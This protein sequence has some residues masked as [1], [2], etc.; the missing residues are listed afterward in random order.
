MPLVAS[1]A[2]F[3]FSAEA[4]PVGL[5]SLG[6]S[7]LAGVSVLSVDAASP[8]EEDGSLEVFLVLVAVAEV[9]VFCAAA[10]S[11]LVLVGGVISGVLLGIGSLTLLLP[12]PLTVTP[13]SSAA[14]AT[15]AT[16]AFTAAPCAC[17]RWG[18]R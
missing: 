17:R 8:L 12:H 3:S 5:A 1:A 10:A 4:P 13:Q 18:S 9:D 7:L 15:S 16:R 6:V 11:A 14:D 2:G